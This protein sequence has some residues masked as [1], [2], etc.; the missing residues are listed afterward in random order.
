MTPTLA[1]VVLIGLIALS[2]LAVIVWCISTDEKYMENW[3]E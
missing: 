2:H 3:K 1:T